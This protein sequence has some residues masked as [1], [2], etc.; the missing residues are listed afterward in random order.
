MNIIQ[1][2]ISYLAIAAAFISSLFSWGDSAMIP[3]T[4][5]YSIPESIPGY[6]V[7]STE[8]KSDWTAQWI[9]DKDNLTEKNVWMCLNKRVKLDKAPETLTAHISADSKYWLYINGETVV[10]E[11]SVK[12]GAD[13]NSG[14]YDSI[15]IAPYLREG[16]NSVC[17][18]VWYWDN[19]TSYS[20]NSSGQGG[21]I[22]EAIGEGVT[23]ISDKSWKVKR[24]S[25]YIDSALY[26][27]NYR[28]PEY[29]IYF[30]ARE[31]MP[32]WISADYDVSSW[33]NATEYAVGGEGA[34]GKL[35]PR[36]IPFL[37]DY[38]LKAYENSADYENY[39]V[40]KLLGE[41]ITVDIPYNAQLTPYLKVIAP[42]GKK[43]RITTENTLIGAVS[44]TYI[45]KEGEQEF[46]ALGW[47][48]GEHITYK[49]PKG[50]TVVSLMYR[51]TGYD[52]S[53]SGDFKCDDEFLDSLWQKSLRTLYV[54]MRDNFMDC[55]D[56][57][58]AQ[59]WG[60]V[61]SEMIMTM[62]SMDS[63]SYL[64]YQKG[65]EAMLSHI[66]DSKVLQTVV[67][68]SGDYFELPVQQL[69]GIVGFLTYYEYTGDEAFIEKVY[70]ASLDYLKL[71]DIG[72]DKLVVHRSG[73]WD[74]P[75][76]GSKAD[77]TAIE[78]AWVYYALSA[79]ERMAEITGEKDDLS[80]IAERKQNLAEG[81]EALWT[82]EGY[83]SKD[84]KKP[85]DR[86]NALAVLSGL[87]D[88]EKYAAVTN[89]L[90][91]TKNSSPYMEYYVLEALCEMGKYEQARDRIKDR[92]DGMMSE[93]YS[94]LWEF[95]ESWRGTMN[96]AWSGGPLVI[97]SKHFAGI[98]PLKAG[99]EEV[100]IDPQYGLSD[101]MSCTVP[102]VKGLITLNYEKTADGYAV[103]LTV[104]EAME[105][106][107]YIPEGA[108]V[109]INSQPYYQNGEYVSGEAGAVEIAEKEAVKV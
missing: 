17:A 41:K 93:D 35:Y 27:P 50:V 7:I 108:T 65:V 45:T 58:R 14:Y 30:D 78:N 22:F 81:Y 33:E 43:I 94:T 4:N 36:G 55:P 1:T 3:Y 87:A 59:W 54:T 62:Y 70:D 23:I 102:S 9:W 57:E 72:E 64:L 96:H 6:S 83:K 67:P 84:V 103:N 98:T 21:F 20:Y 97:M 101:T 76:W 107:V 52:S 71:W 49:I 100:K 24:H 37:K 79:V 16:E 68:I 73:S 12:R 69:A 92:Y 48:N 8:E 31:D 47:F 106:L 109:N 88:E 46:E 18:L 56:R 90:T 34:Y 29:S 44:A 77:M 86:A 61:T 10:F 82:E 11:G 74:W 91:T 51:E 104:P 39:T 75:D 28:L 38:G 53:F 5:D 26:P 60:D 63:S 42:A 40:N 25:A 19:E 80:F 85:D 95:W 105:A 13:E 32:E 15:D 89:V 66:D 2:I 99:Y